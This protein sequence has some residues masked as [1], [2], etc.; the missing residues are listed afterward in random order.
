MK[1]F[2]WN[3]RGIGNLDS[4]IA[5]K[6]FFF[7]HRPLLMF[8]AKPIVPLSNIPGWYL[9]FYSSYFLLSE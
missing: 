3:I 8:V 2:Y 9:E 7:N 1:I 5:L 6:D 4:R